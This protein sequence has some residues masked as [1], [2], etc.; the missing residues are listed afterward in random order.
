M[1]H[2]RRLGAVEPSWDIPGDKPE[3]HDIVMDRAV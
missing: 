2:G 3:W 1:D